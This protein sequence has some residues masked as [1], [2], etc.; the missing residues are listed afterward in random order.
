M[1]DAASLHCSV[2]S[3]LRCWAAGSFIYKFPVLI[4]GREE[5]PDYLAERSI[6]ILGAA[7]Y[8]TPAVMILFVTAFH[9][10]GG[11]L[12]FLYPVYASVSSLRRSSAKNC[13]IGGIRSYRLQHA[14]MGVDAFSGMSL[15]GA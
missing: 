8:G 2:S 11:S 3:S 9:D 5:L 4:G 10:A 15:M 13:V 14:R 1:S 12:R 7:V 6:G